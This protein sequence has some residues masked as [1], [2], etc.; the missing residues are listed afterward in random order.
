MEAPCGDLVAARLHRE[1]QSSVH[2]EGEDKEARSH[3]PNPSLCAEHCVK[4][5][6][7]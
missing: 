4:L 3:R 6:M 1:I 2:F 5:N 7:I